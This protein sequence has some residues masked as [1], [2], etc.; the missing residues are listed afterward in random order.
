MLQVTLHYHSNT[1]SYNKQRLVLFSIVC[2]DAEHVVCS[3][4]WTSAE[5]SGS[6][7]LSSFESSQYSW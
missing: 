6:T 1:P 4:D 3:T 5:A 7:A 2:F